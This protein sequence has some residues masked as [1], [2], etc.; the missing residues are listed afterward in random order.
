MLD[1][2]LQN[3]YSAPE[4]L[5]NSHCFGG[6]QE[7]TSSGNHRNDRRRKPTG[8]PGLVSVSDAPQVCR[9]EFTGTP[10]PVM[11][12]WAMALLPGMI[13][14]RSLHGV[15][16]VT[17]LSGAVCWSSQNCTDRT[18]DANRKTFRGSK[19]GKPDGMLLHPLESLRIPAKDCK[20]QY[21]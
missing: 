20:V 1:R 7:L 10:S 12:P 2:L 18:F 21:E 6:K 4:W 16:M 14:N 3:C 8:W 5:L 13:V 15:Y 9:Y 17:A 11:I 19:V